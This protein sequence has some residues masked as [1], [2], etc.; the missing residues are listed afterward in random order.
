M[1]LAI[2][3]FTDSDP[4]TPPFCLDS[5]EFYSIRRAFAKNLSVHRTEKDGEWYI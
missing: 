5:R 1:D 4:S 3:V 2:I